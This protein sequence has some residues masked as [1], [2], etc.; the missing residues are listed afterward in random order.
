MTVIKRRKS[1]LAAALSG[2]VGGV[3]LQIAGNATAMNY[4]VNGDRVF[5]SGD[6]TFAD[7]VSLPALLA[8]AQAEGRPIREVVLRTSNGGA[9][10][11]G[12]WLQ[13]IIRTSGLN[14]IV[15]GNCISSCSIMQ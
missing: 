6:V 10:I 14:T 13:G 2:L 3:A 5:L 4:H 1:R 8:K 12:E 11:A 9:L 7:V 15:S